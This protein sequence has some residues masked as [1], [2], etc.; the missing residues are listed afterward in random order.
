MQQIS[1]LEQLQRALAQP[2]KGQHRPDIFSQF[3]QARASHRMVADGMFWKCQH[4]LAP[5]HTGHA[6]T[7]KKLPGPCP[8]KVPGKKKKPT[9]PCS[10]APALGF[11]PAAKENE[12]TRPGKQLDGATTRDASQ[13]SSI[14]SFFRPVERAS[15]TAPG[16]TRPAPSGSGPTGHTRSSKGKAR[17]QEVEGVQT[18]LSFGSACC[19]S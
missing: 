1:K 19:G 8:G 3:W 11:T 2:C 13:P 16:T 10:V 5:Q 15:Q 18:K 12:A 17:K 14:A 4:C 7:S 6:A 9:Q